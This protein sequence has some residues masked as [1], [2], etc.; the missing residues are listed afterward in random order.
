MTFSKTISRSKEINSLQNEYN[1]IFSVIQRLETFVN[2]PDQGS[3]VDPNVA[4]QIRTVIADTQITLDELHA[5]IK[6]LAPSGVGSGRRAVVQLRCKYLWK[7][8]TIQATLL[9]LRAR[10]DAL[11]LVLGMW[12]R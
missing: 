9:R 11:S 10:R 2:D 6:S 1:S 12:S 3:S 5:N 4:T 8:K 7:E